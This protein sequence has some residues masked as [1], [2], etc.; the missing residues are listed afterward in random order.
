MQLLRGKSIN[1]HTLH[2]ASLDTYD[3]AIATGFNNA[4]L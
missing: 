2:K 4:L 1:I 3:D